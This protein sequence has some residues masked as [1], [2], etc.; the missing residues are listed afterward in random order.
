MR[1]FFLL[2]AFSF[3]G[4]AA[5]VSAPLA[6]Q[7][8]S[9]NG[10]SIQGTITDPTGAAVPNASITLLNSE[11]GGRKDLKSDGSGYYSVGPLTPGAYKITIS[12]PGFQTL[13]VTTVIR[14]GTATPGSF[15]LPV[16]SAGETVQV[17]AGSIQLNTDQA[18]VSDV[19]TSEQIQ[20]LPINGRNF[21][22]VAQIEPGVVLQAGGSFDPTKAGIRL[23]PSAASP[24]APPV[25]CWTAR[26]SPTKPSAPP[27]STSRRAPWASSRS[28]ARPRTFPAM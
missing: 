17:D 12:S 3:A 7:V 26:T 24:D 19:L 22:D 4:S 2:A 15:K 6:A 14:V 27:S 11:T 8:V 25:F 21:L 5:V 13:A 28:T 18:G 9:T 16:G 10:G 20:T 1:K 23:C